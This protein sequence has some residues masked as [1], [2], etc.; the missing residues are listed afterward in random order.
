[1][2][3]LISNSMW[4]D[5]QAFEKNANSV[6]NIF[7]NINTNN[8]NGVPAHTNSPAAF[9]NH[10]QN[11][12]VAD[13][14]LSASFSTITSIADIDHGFTKG[15]NIALLLNDDGTHI[16][17]IIIAY[18]EKSGNTLLAQQMSSYFISTVQD[19]R[20]LNSLYVSEG[21]SKLIY[22]TYDLN[23]KNYAPSM[24]TTVR[25]AAVL[26]F[27]MIEMF[28]SVG[29]DFSPYS[30]AK[31]AYEFYLSNRR[32]ST[33]L[34]LELEHG[35]IV[36]KRD[37][38]KDRGSAFYAPILQVLAYYKLSHPEIGFDQL[39]FK[40]V[41]PNGGYAD[42]SKI[43]QLKFV[44][45]IFK[46]RFID[47]SA[48][49][50]FDIEDYTGNANNLLI[51]GAPGT[52]KSYKVKSD[53]EPRYSGTVERVTFFN[54]F[55]YTDFVGGLKPQRDQFGNVRYTFVPGA[56]TRVLVEA[57]NAPQQ[58][59]LLIIEEL[60]RSNASAVFGEV[61]QLL[62]RDSNGISTYSVFNGE[63]ADYLDSEVNG[64]TNFKKTGIRL[65]GN[66]SIVAT[67][68]PA[69]QGVQQIDTA[70]KRR[71]ISE[72]M[73]IDFDVV[74]YGNKVTADNQFT[75]KQVGEELNNYLLN[76]VKIEEDALIGQYF[77]KENEITNPKIFA[78]KLLGY[79]WTDAARYSDGLFIQK[80]FAE[81]QNTFIR[82][83]VLADVLTLEVFKGNPKQSSLPTENQDDEN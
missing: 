53:I 20:S 15:P 32:K 5:M 35:K 8:Q 66:M 46:G 1:M 43:N 16:S 13:L 7:K 77:L 70:F 25:S 59:H 48:F 76:E 63:L 75:W 37:S 3:L 50:N 33:D 55:D 58:N 71:W 83:P 57:L 41:S 45:D 81:V 21:Y 22:S 27:K 10:M 30:S 69:D 60:N 82:N 19:E 72:Y 17:D 47:G 54:D 6:P 56:F 73:P 2:K 61:F 80:T 18:S 78:D 62:D 52:G 67:M 64:F 31:E 65:P 79:L 26:G 29:N 4:N 28:P 40:I 23:Q 14:N 38:Q 39:E 11:R 44:D 74:S 36:L 34:R 24:Q 49:Q 51:F 42:I 68:N 12:I 9:F